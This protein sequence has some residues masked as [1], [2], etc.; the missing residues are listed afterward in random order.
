MRIR[1]FLRIL[2]TL[3]IL[4][5]LFI[6]GIVVC[7]AWNLIDKAN[8]IYWV[9]LLY[10]DTVVKIVASII[11]AVII[12]MSLK[13]IFTGSREKKIK[14]KTLKESE[15]G[16]IR[17]SVMALQDM[18]NRYVMESKEVRN[19]KASIITNEKGID[20]DLRLAVVPGTNIPELTSALQSGLK[21]NIETYSGIF[22]NN[23]DI[24]VDD[25]SLAGK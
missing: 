16:S 3:Y 11:A 15:S 9:D 12:V 18:V 14:T 25:T 2:L 1:I 23:V 13:F 22:V 5:F 8:P 4:S 20:I 17:V 21:D 10:G 24:L 7:C 19:H 6:A